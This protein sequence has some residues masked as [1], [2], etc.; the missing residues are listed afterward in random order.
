[1][2][3]SQALRSEWR[4]QLQGELCFG[5]RRRDIISIACL[6]F[7]RVRQGPRTIFFAGFDLRQRL[8]LGFLRRRPWQTAQLGIL[9]E[10]VLVRQAQSSS[11]RL[12]SSLP[13]HNTVSTIL[14]MRAR[15]S[16][17][18]KGG[19]DQKLGQPYRRRVLKE[20]ARRRLLQQHPVLPR[21][22]RLLAEEIGH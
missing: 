7:I 14:S 9:L 18:G 5:R 4:G 2:L 15:P 16:T 6:M 11:N 22:T 3:S 10:A 12:S 20:G 19:P 13:I 1:M 21:Y 17:A 8:S